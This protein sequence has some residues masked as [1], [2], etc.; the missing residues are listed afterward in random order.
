MRKHGVFHGVCS[1]LQVVRAQFRVVLSFTFFFL[2]GN[3]SFYV[4]KVTGELKSETDF[5]LVQTFDS[6]H[7][8]VRQLTVAFN[9]ACKPWDRGRWKTMGT[10]F[11]FS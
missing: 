9:P 4:G 2:L 7:V 3:M 6:T 1:T 5:E 10:T 11:Y 8:L